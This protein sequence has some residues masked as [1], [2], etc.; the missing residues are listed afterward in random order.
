MAR[1]SLMAVVMIPVDELIWCG[2][3][4]GGLRELT[5]DWERTLLS[6]GS[7]LSMLLVAT[8]EAVLSVVPPGVTGAWTWLLVR[9]GWS[10]GWGRPVG[11]EEC[12]AELMSVRVVWSVPLNRVWS[13]AA[14]AGGSDVLGASLSWGGGELRSGWWLV[15]RVMV[16]VVL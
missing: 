8:E 12:R 10:A 11:E 3:C 1:C 4:G 7:S 6:M 16:V 14:I 13:R 15:P 5:S 9:K 2:D